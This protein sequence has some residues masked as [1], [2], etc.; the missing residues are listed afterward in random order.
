M[1]RKN[2]TKRSRKP[3]NRNGG[4][5]KP[6]Q[7]RSNIIVK[8]RYRFVS[9]SATTTAITSTNLR[10]ICGALCAVANTTLY[11]IADSFKLHSVEVWTPPASQ[12]AAATCSVEWTGGSF[13]PAVE[14]S[15]TTCSVSEPAHIKT[16]PPQGSEPSFW[17]NA[18]GSLVM[19][20]TCPVGSIIDVV[21][22]HVLADDA[23]AGATYGVAAAVLGAM[24]YPPLDGTTDKYLPVSLGTTT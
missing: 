12:G 5:L 21:A 14:V 24:Y 4:A 23:T 10:G 18:L 9:T 13:G 1:Q 8:H 7:L 6:P 17:S 22:S 16:A 11:M 2:Q 15:D 20:L 19:N 3:R